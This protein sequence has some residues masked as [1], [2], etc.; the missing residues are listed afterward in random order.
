MYEILIII[1]SVMAALLTQEL[2]IS[3]KWGAVKA[4]AFVSLLFGLFFFF[5]SNL[6]SFSNFEIPIYVHPL[7]SPAAMGAS[8]VAMSSERTIPN[9]KWMFIGGVFFAVLFILAKPTL[10]GYGGLLG[11]G[12][13]FSVVMTVG[14]IRLYDVLKKG[15]F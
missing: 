11:T 15:P 13:C 9:R 1:T 4:S 6:P 8:F 3:R 7:L 10:D 5:L 14:I 12:A 2:N